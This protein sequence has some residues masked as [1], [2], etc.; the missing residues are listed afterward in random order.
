MLHT[1]L[2]NTSFSSV[3]FKYTPSSIDCYFE[4]RQNCYHEDMIMSKTKKPI[5]FLAALVAGMFYFPA[6]KAGLDLQNQTEIRIGDLDLD[7]DN[8][9]LR[10]EVAEYMFYY[11]DRDGNEVLT[12][13]EYHAERAI[14]VVPYE[15]D[16]ITIIDLDNDGQDDGVRYTQETFLQKAMI[17]EYKPDAKGIKAYNFMDIYFLRLDTDESRAIEMSEWQKAYEK[18]AVSKPN[19]APEAANNDHYAQ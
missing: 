10:K 1:T 11:F 13:G 19:H 3:R 14:A 17:G 4:N 7:H 18:H 9:I 2:N 16:A 12:K 6:A 5:L 8:R 15:G